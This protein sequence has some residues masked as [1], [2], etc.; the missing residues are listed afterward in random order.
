MLL[1]VL[2][3]FAG[4]SLTFAAGNIRMGPIQVFPEISYNG[5]YND[6]IFSEST[7]EE[8]DIIHT[9][10]PSIKLRYG[11]TQDNSF[12]AGYQV[13]VVRYADFNDTDYEDHRLFMNLG[14]KSP[15][16]FYL[17]A[18]DNYQNTSDPYGSESQFR[19]GD[20]T[21]R[22]NN[23]LN[24]TAGFGFAERYAAEAKFSN[25]VERFDRFEDEF[26]DRMENSIGLSVLYNVSSKTSLLAEF[27][28]TSVE[29]DQQNDGI[30]LDENGT[31][32][33]DEWRSDNSQD[34]DL[35]DLFF[36]ARFN[37]GGKLTGE[38]KVGY[39]TVSFKNDEDRN[40]N[41]YNDDNAFLM[42]VNL[43]YMPTPRTE[44][45]LVARRSRAVSYSADADT[46]ASASYIDVYGS[47][48]LIQKLMDRFTLDLSFSRNMNDYLDV[49]QGNDDKILYTHTLKADLSYDIKNWLKTG[50]SVIRTDKTAT[51]DTYE[52]EE[53]TSNRFGF[54]AKLIF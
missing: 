44:I 15:M 25:F 16:G 12:T 29:F 5:E 26:Q 24:L 6:N 32:G 30:D 27:R 8:S 20:Q 37:P 7:D 17:K 45:I 52:N 41:S 40:D 22:W 36:G 46:D 34:H 11:N 38:A 28:R 35:N 10:T 21:K 43:S 19:I 50:V 3:F 51:S 39:Q 53:F 2:V 23:R 13:G 1:S 49:K 18:G 9:I 48:E 14:Y 47:L 31:V 33:A 4:A 42:E 54:Y